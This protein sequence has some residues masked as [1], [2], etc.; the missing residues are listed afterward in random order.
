VAGP[1][2][3]ALQ[4]ADLP[5][6]WARLGFAV[7]DG[8]VALGGVSI[9]LCGPDGSGIT[10]W[11]LAGLRGKTAADIDGLP[12]TLIE[13]AA[14][15][16]TSSTRV[17]PEHPN[18]A[19]GIDH[20]VIVTPDF[21][22]TSA[23]LDA[24]GLALKRVR[25]AGDRRQGFRRL[26]PAIMEIVEAPDADRVAFWGLTIVVADLARAASH[27]DGHLSPVR[28]AVQPG[29]QIATLAREAG[30][31]TRLAFMDPEPTGPTGPVADSPVD[32]EPT[33]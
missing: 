13:E 33:D 26:G 16:V 1:Q 4:I 18:L 17:E 30:L 29:R 31:S 32:P 10:G 28:P 9:E 22:R 25:H 12:T 14:A 24:A 15:A 21:A 27:S 2:L 5:E 23:A 11:T 6:S 20:V 8:R 3:A 7:E 19:L